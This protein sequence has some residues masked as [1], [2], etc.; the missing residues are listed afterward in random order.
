MPL[1]VERALA[2]SLFLCVSNFH[3]SLSVEAAF[4]AQLVATPPRDTTLQRDIFLPPTLDIA[5]DAPLPRAKYRPLMPYRRL[6][7]RWR[8]MAYLD[9]SPRYQC[10]HF[11]HSPP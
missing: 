11:T 2:F 1:Y 8:L 7:A 6:S 10:T 5:D 9:A 3:I 4:D